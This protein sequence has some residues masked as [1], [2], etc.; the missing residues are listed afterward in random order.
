M[1]SLCR[2]GSNHTRAGSSLCEY[3]NDVTMHFMTFRRHFV[4]TV[5]IINMVDIVWL[6]LGK[7]CNVSHRRL[8]AG[9]SSIVI[10]RKMT[11]LRFDVT[12]LEFSPKIKKHLNVPFSI[13]VHPSL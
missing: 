2:R 1:K 8:Q 11:S 12:S 9:L 10:R 13:R 4:V 7:Q 6:G 5:T 3:D